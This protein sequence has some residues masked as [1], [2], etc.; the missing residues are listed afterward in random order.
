M[1][2]M[3]INPDE[4]ERNDVNGEKSSKRMRMS[5]KEKVEKQEEKKDEDAEEG[6]KEIPEKGNEAAEINKGT[7]IYRILGQEIKQ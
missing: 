5:E 7:T 4:L 1:V 2:Q 3:I 6:V